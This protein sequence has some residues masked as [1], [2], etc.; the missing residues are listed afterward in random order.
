MNALRTR[1]G[2]H[3]LS[4]SRELMVTILDRDATEDDARVFRDAAH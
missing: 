4:D 2:S 3:G 1:V